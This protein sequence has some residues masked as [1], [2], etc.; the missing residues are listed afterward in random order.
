MC[1]KRYVTALE[2]SLVY[3]SVYG[4]VGPGVGY[5]G[6]QVIVICLMFNVDCDV[7]LGGDIVIIKL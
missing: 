5:D 7:G 1:C 3:Y 6:R 4:F 2:C